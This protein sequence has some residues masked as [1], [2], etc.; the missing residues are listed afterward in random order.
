MPRHVAQFGKEQGV[1][2]TAI[3]KRADAEQWTRDLAGKIRAA[4][5]AKLAREV[6]RPQVSTE[7]AK[8][9]EREIVEANATIQVQIVREHRVDI[10]RARGLSQRLL[11]ELETAIGNRV[12]LQEIAGEATKDDRSPQR[13]IMLMKAVALPEHAG[14][15]ESVVRSLK[16]LVQMEREAF[17]ITEPGAHDLENPGRLWLR[18]PE[19]PFS[20]KC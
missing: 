13:R 17:A 18:L 9:T 7:V 14:T 1:L 15:L 16:H 10:Q 3:Q 11:G 5:D 12:I 8:S 19:P 4:A 2:H 20:A 6:A